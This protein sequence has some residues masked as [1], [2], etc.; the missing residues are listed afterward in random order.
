MGFSC[1]LDLSSAK[2]QQFITIYFSIDQKNINFFDHHECHAYYGYYGRG[3]GKQKTCVVT[4]DG[5][6]D[7]SNATIWISKGKKLINVY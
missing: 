2:D 1:I 7:K 6:G 3:I 4:L 5:G